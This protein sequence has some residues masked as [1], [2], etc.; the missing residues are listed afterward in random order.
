MGSDGHLH[1]LW[2]MG[3]EGG[4]EEGDPNTRDDAASNH[5]GSSEPSGVPL[6]AIVVG[7]PIQKI[8]EDSRRDRKRSKSQ[9]RRTDIQLQISVVVEDTLENSIVAL[10]RIWYD[11]AGRRLR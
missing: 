3:T 10:T 11:A 5:Q 2:K 6:I 1:T 7:N 8:R 9:E 4:N